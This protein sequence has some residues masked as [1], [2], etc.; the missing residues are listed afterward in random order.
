MVGDWEP[1]RNSWWEGLSTNTRRFCEDS[2][3]PGLTVTTG[4]ATISCLPLSTWHLPSAV[5][6][7]YAHYVNPCLHRETEAQ[8]GEVSTGGNQRESELSSGQ[9]AWQVLGTRAW[10]LI[11][12]PPAIQQSAKA[13]HIPQAQLSCPLN[14]KKLA[15]VYYED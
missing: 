11:L 5:L 12:I 10:V 4:K 9:G 8:R 3:Q 13:L 15:L 1:Q 7:L 2:G 14:T 6:P